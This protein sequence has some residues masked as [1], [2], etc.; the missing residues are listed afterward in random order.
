[1]RGSRGW[2]IAIA[3]MVMLCASAPPPAGAASSAPI[4]EYF[5]TQARDG[6][7]LAPF[8]PPG[9]GFEGPCGVGVDSDADF[10]VSD[11][12]HHSIDIFTSGRA[13]LTQ[14]AKVDPL[15]GPCGLAFDAKGTLY[16]NT[17]HGQVLRYVPAKFPLGLGTAYGPPTAIGEGEATGVAVDPATGRVYV[18]DRTHI[19][20][21]E[22]TGVPVVDGEGHPLHIGEGTLE[23]GYGLAFVQPPA[24]TAGRLYVADAASNTVKAYDPS[25][26]VVDPVAE[27]DAHE[28][29]GGGFASL[30]DSAV[31]VDRAD[32]LLY[33]AD[34]LQPQGSERPEAAIYGF[35]ADGKYAGRLKYNVIDARPPG[36]AVDNSLA[37]TAGRVYVTSGNTEGARLF[38]YGP[39]SLS[40]QGSCAPEGSCPQGG[41]GL[42]AASGSTAGNLEV[43]GPD[44]GVVAQ[45]RQR[46]S[47][48][49]TI[50][51]KGNLRVSVS[52]GLTPGKLPRAGTAP[53]AVSVA[54]QI[55]TTDGS[56]PP[57]LKTLKIEI[58][59]HGHLDNAGLPSCPYVKIRTASSSRA[60][61]S[62][63]DALVGKGRFQASIV[64]AGQEPYPT[65]GKLLVFNGERAG[66]PV[67]YGQIY[68]PRPFATSF[69]IVFTIAKL[70]GGTYGTVLTAQLPRALG[71][72]GYLTGI[73]MRLARRFSH[74]GRHRSFLSA[75][76][77]APKGFA[78]ALFPLAR[79][80]FRFDGTGW[81]STTLSGQC[82]VRG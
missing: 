48:G 81:L 2:L 67:L 18:D 78:K 50:A 52:G 15:D 59:R 11:Y 29:P 28:A 34:L 36:L 23:D 55:A 80:S 54:G 43:A 40:L 35:A 25:L 38:A 24:L 7:E 57:Q 12:Y 10:Y 68:S 69:V 42:A 66:K 27:I 75:G 72:W 26:D 64:L 39:G 60:L 82:G 70:A 20:V 13:F 8:P 47:G 44:G 1:M 4:F 46:S 58:N 41:V 45:P 30:R 16:V 63:R 19:S 79:T 14:I 74:E 53:I 76:C 32:G 21:Y 49:T 62:C 77:P 73:Q 6:G 3:T 33:V 61:A 9:S 37:G 56:P 22:P 65:E 5:A 71:S 51:Q 17:Y 31:A